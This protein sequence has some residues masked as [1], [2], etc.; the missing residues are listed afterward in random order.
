MR[1]LWFGVPGNPAIPGWG[2]GCVCLGTGFGFALPVLAGVCSSCVW[3]W[4]FPA[5]A[6]SWL[7]RWGMCPLARALPVP[8]HSRVGPPAVRGCVG[9]AVGGVSPPSS[10]FFFR[11]SCLRRGGLWVWFSAPL[12]CGSVVVAVACSSLGP[13]GSRSPSPLPLGSSFLFF[14][15]SCVRVRVA[16]SLPLLPWGC[17]PACPG[18]LLVWPFGGCVVV[19]GR[20]FWTGVF[21]LGGVVPRC[22]IGGSSG[23]RLLVSPGRG[24]SRPRWN[25]CAASRLCDYPPRFPS[26]PLAG[27]CALMGWWLK[28][29][30]FFFRGRVAC[31]SLRLPWAG[32]RT[33]MQTVWLPGSLL[34]LW[35]ATGRVLALYVLWF[36]YTHGLVAHSVG[37]GSG[38]ASW[39]VAPA[40]MLTSWV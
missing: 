19:V 16:G 28:P 8:R 22:P 27:G 40:G 20:V 26:F 17:A 33:G 5:P 21:G 4:T 35:V 14:V 15:F 2:L 1:V 36:M 18:C 39:A 7:G 11:P 37:L 32:A 34:A 9:V 38:S 12:C 10:Y 29:S 30:V 6:Y 25:G 24:V 3:L 23:C 31:S 13:L